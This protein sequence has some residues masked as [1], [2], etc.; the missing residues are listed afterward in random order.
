MTVLTC[1]GHFWTYTFF[2]SISFLFSCYTWIGSQVICDFVTTWT[3]YHLLVYISNVVHP[4]FLL[5]IATH[6]ALRCGQ[7]KRELA[8]ARELSTRAWPY[9]QLR[10]ATFFSWIVH[11]RSSTT[12]LSNSLQA[13]E[14]QC[15]QM[16]EHK[17]PCFPVK[18]SLFHKKCPCYVD[19][20]TSNRAQNFPKQGN[21]LSLGPKI[22]L[23][24]GNF[25]AS[26]NT[27]ERQAQSNSLQATGAFSSFRL[28]V[29][30]RLLERMDVELL[31]CTI[32]LKKLAPRSCLYGHALGD[33]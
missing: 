22:S 6:F 33:S 16:M 20:D 32:Q 17:F 10:G 25:P 2:T 23:K 15:C 11:T 24:Q 9:K 18:I 19:L 26:G 29:A 12:I 13:T 21:F 30:C 8:I 4:T 1:F 14:R 3:P 27:A 28:S 7:K 5:R 31:V